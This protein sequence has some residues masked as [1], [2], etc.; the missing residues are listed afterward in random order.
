MA[1]GIFNLNWPWSW[2]EQ[3]PTP[4]EYDVARSVQPTLDVGT[5]WPRDIQFVQNL[6]TVD[7]SASSAFT[8]PAPAAG[9]ARLWIQLNVSIALVTTIT[10][11][12][13][14]RENLAASQQMTWAFY[15]GAPDNGFEIPLIG[16]QYYA[17][18]VGTVTSS[19]PFRGNSELY[20][21]SDRDEQGRVVVLNG[22]TATTATIT[23]LFIDAPLNQPLLP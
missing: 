20:I 13:L 17:G 18:N 14:F 5:K 7:A 1:R 19:R 21:R 4:G 3:D 12:R 6:L 11:T 16:G 10:Q 9:N 15:F 23:G 22:A 8:L 2:L